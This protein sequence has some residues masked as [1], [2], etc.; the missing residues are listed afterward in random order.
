MLNGLLSTTLWSAYL[1]CLSISDEQTLLVAV[2]LCNDLHFV[3]QAHCTKLF[4]ISNVSLI[5]LVL[6]IR[7]R[8]TI[9]SLPHHHLFSIF[10]ALLMHLSKESKHPIWQFLL[11][12]W[13]HVI[14]LP[15]LR[16]IPTYT[17]ALKKTHHKP[18][19]SSTYIS[20]RSTP[21]IMTLSISTLVSRS[22][23]ALICW[24]RSLHWWFHYHHLSLFRHPTNV[25]FVNLAQ[26]DYSETYALLSKP[27]FICTIFP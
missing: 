21:T 3:P 20:F 7:L 14:V 23:W 22:P 15:R 9:L 6:S 11:L 2:S 12:V 27:K 8:F 4:W 16:R 17:L 5:H 24:N 13:H 1:P 25:H 18:F 26:R 10:W 19:F